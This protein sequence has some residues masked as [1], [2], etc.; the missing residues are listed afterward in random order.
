M[1]KATLISLELIFF[2]QLIEKICKIFFLFSDVNKI[3]TQK[4]CKKKMPKE[5]IY[6]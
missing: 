2:P 6:L 1:P 5:I 3:Y 4:K